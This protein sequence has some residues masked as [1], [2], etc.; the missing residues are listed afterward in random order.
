MEGT[1]LPRFF[2]FWQDL[3]L[4]PS[5]ILLACTVSAHALSASETAPE[6]AEG[7]LAKVHVTVENLLTHQGEIHLMISND[8]KHF[9]EPEHANFLTVA[10]V[11]FVA[12]H[13]II[14]E[15][16]PGSYA[17]TVLHD[18]NGNHE[19]D[20][21]FFGMPTEPFGFSRN[22]KLFFGPPSYQ[23]CVVELNP[24]DTALQIRLR[25]E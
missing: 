7:A 6:Q 9:L 3:G 10:T 24:G 1:Q 18:L 11:D 8:E 23:S 16:P 4:I 19:L 13:P 22:P 2:E 15:V 20:K 25:G 21:T 17:I 5:L 14:A 12:R